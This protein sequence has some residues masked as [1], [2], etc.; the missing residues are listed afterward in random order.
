MNYT[1]FRLAKLSETDGNTILGSATEFVGT[2]ETDFEFVIGQRYRLEAEIETAGSPAAADRYVF[3]V[4]MFSN[5]ENEILLGT[6]LAEYSGWVAE[7]FSGGAGI[8][9]ANVTLV[10]GTGP[11]P[12]QRNTEFYLEV[13]DIGG[14]NQEIRYS[15]DFY[16]TEDLNNWITKNKLENDRRFKFSHF[17]SSNETRNE[18]DSAYFR[19]KSFETAFYKQDPI[20][21]LPIWYATLA[22]LSSPT[23]GS[24]KTKNKW[25]DRGANNLQNYA[26]GTLIEPAA[27]NIWVEL[28]TFEPEDLGS[29]LLLFLKSESLANLVST[30]N[31]ADSSNF[32]RTV[33]RGA[34]VP[35]LEP[36]V[37]VGTLNG[38]LVCSVPSE[39]YFTSL[40][41]MPSPSQS[42]GFVIVARVTGGNAAFLRLAGAGVA[43]VSLN[44]NP[45]NNIITTSVRNTVEAFSRVINAP[46][47]ASGWAIL[48][49]A[50]EF[51][52]GTNQLSI[53]AAVNGETAANLTVTTAGGTYPVNII[54][55]LFSGVSG[56]SPVAGWQG[57][58]ATAVIFENTTITGRKEN[59][60][61]WAAWKFGLQ[62]NL[63]ASHPFKNSPT[64]LGSGR[65]ADFVRQS[66]PLIFN[67]SDLNFITN[68]DQ[69]P[70]NSDSLFRADIWLGQNGFTPDTLELRLIRNNNT[71]DAVELM[72]D[73]GFS[74]AEIPE[75][76]ISPTDTRLS[77]TENGIFGTNNSCWIA[78]G[79]LDP[80]T[81]SGNYLRLRN[82]FIDGS[83]LQLGQS[84]RVIAIMTDS[85]TS[86]SYATLTPVLN[87]VVPTPQFS[88]IKHEFGNY[89]NREISND[90]TVA[91]NE[92]FFAVLTLDAVNYL[93]SFAGLAADLRSV[94]CN[95]QYAPS[96]FS[97]V[98][99]RSF[100]Y[101]FITNQGDLDVSVAGGVYEIQMT[102]RA[103]NNFSSVN[104]IA[105]IIWT[106]ELE[107]QT[108]SGTDTL[109]VE[110][111]VT[112]RVR[113][114]EDY[115]VG[116]PII[117][118]IT[119][120]D[121]TQFIGGNEVEINSICRD[122]DFAVVCIEL[123]PFGAGITGANLIALFQTL[124]LSNFPAT[125]EQ[126]SYL[127]P[128]LPLLTSAVFS[129]VDTIFDP[130]TRKAYYILNMQQ[131]SPAPQ[132]VNQ[133]ACVVQ[134][135]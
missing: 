94:S 64:L 12:T 63:P 32:G 61:G 25:Y 130:T 3:N 105:N 82:L 50:F 76:S 78:R 113:P 21:L 85:T 108:G 134:L 66:P 35:G 46:S 89:N 80:W 95:I 42:L 38:Q 101:D 67:A 49:F 90:A 6:G 52:G 59:L 16:A 100:S 14:G 8:H 110:V 34:T 57:E 77:G 125:E 123:E 91:P 97:Q 122:E 20:T 47:A 127:S 106:I 119:L 17:L 24:V 53:S 56:G 98:A 2:G 45:A 36:S 87:P 4:C 124:P 72:T 112:L 120:L 58:V 15:F 33:A 1:S 31:W 10:A 93:N 74:G 30:G 115:L 9:V 92:R 128:D 51:N 111:P 103:I 126:E 114:T 102:D 48:Y 79:G 73:L 13:E 133:I 86:E 99:P 135:F 70:I 55:T 71:T 62:A 41:T 121:Y 22:G 23:R 60:E 28:P 104:R 68:S 27:E 131:L 116:S 44:F 40:P 29:D 11:E 7:L 107:F 129:S 26:S 39:G 69:I 84:Y 75:T 118:D 37:A 83:Y 18:G 117:T 43:G 109:T 81:I 5:F 132:P 96:I 54:N 65:T 88:F 19:P